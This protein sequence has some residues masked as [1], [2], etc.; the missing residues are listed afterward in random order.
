LDEDLE[1]VFQTLYQPNDPENPYR[2]PSEDDG[3]QFLHWKDVGV[4]ATM[5]LELC[6]KK[7]IP[8]YIVWSS[9]VVSSFVPAKV[10]QDLT[11]LSLCIR[12]N[13]AFFYGD[14]KTKE[15]IAKMEQK[16]PK[17]H[18]PT[19]VAVDG[20]REAKTP[21]ADE[22]QDLKWDGESPLIEH[23]THYKTAP[24]IM[25]R[26]R[27]ALHKKGICPKVQLSGPTKIGQLV[28]PFRQK[29]EK[30]A[31]V[32]AMP[33]NDPACQKFARVFSK[34]LGW[35]F[36]YRGESME[37]LSSRAL[38]EMMKPP[39]R[40]NFTMGQE[41]QVLTRQSHKCALCGD[42]LPVQGYQ[43]DHVVARRSGGNDDLDNI[44]ALCGLCHIGKCYTENT[45]SV[46]QDH[47]LMSRFNRETHEA[48][49][50]SAKPPQLVANLHEPNEKWRPVLNIDVRRCRYNG[51]MQ[52]VH[53][54]PIFSPVDSIEPATVGELGD[55]NWVNLGN[56]KHPLSALPYHGAGWYTRMS[57][58]FLLSYGIIDWSHVELSFTASAHLPARYLQERLAKLEE[59]W[60]EVDVDGLPKLAINAMLGLW[61]KP[62]RYKYRLFTTNDTEDVR[63]VPRSSFSQADSWR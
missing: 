60:T 58:E 11:P 13:H 48:F 52:H 1:E 37:V 63:P 42:R 38:E 55:Y 5:V 26:I 6:K 49:H 39:K 14:T 19:E 32:H 9:C 35:E 23:D 43:L 27:I 20:R 12:G 57:C 34:Y 45:N 61:G 17:L 18:C 54:L 28:V 21:A 7:Q 53:D 2:I 62:K 16:L 30:F 44:Q 29:G 10:D 15:L 41:R 47:L 24:D 33:F 56:V 59:L 36:I 3:V 51:L 40:K 25:P 22:W 50:N 8:L 31:Y 46:E 4:S